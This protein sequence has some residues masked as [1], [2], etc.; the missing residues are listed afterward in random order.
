M[1]WSQFERKGKT[2]KRAHFVTTSFWGHI[3]DVNAVIIVFFLKTFYA[4]AKY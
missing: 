2:R 1:S 3:G 4:F